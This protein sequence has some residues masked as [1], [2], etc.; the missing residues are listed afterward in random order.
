MP[1]ATGETIRVLQEI[2]PAARAHPRQGPLTDREMRWAKAA[3]TYFR[4]NVN[5]DT[6]LAG[7]QPNYAPFT[8]WD[9]SAHIAAVVAARNFGFIDEA[10]FDGR[11]RKI[12]T[13]L[14]HMELFRDTLPN[15][16]YSADNGKMVDWANQPGAL[17]WS[18]LD[19]GRFLVWLKILK[20][21]FP[22]YAELVDR[23]VMRWDWSKLMDREGLMYGA[24]YYQRNENLLIH[25][26][27]GRLG[28]EEYCARGFGLWGADTTKA[29][30]YEPFATV[31]VSGEDI[32]FDARD[33]E[34]VHAP[35]F[36]VSESYVLDGIEN[37]WDWPDDEN[38]D[39][40]K[41]SDRQMAAFAWRVYKAQENRYRETGIL[42]ART[43]DAVDQ[44]PY[45]VYGT[46]LGLGIPW[47]T[48]SH[49]GEPMP[50]LACLNSKAAL[51]LWVLFASDY[52]DLLAEAADSL[53]DPEKGFYVGRYEPTGKINSAVTLNGNGVILEIL[54]FKDTGK[55]LVHSGKPSHWDLFFQKH[56][57]PEKA[58]PPWKYQPRIT[59]H[60][61]D[62]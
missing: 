11:I 24:S 9:I 13:W 58:L 18:A 4:N 51:G 17:G 55:L 15:Q 43:E 52:T 39:V 28:Y 10:E 12:L 41:H 37:N 62:P 2:R 29:S 49:E 6:G 56:D 44:A 3:W 26:V 46:I 57:L 22:V 20:E 45:F 40:T 33:L 38:R 27:E 59:V 42:T 32:P 53:Y 16:F 14:N 25:Y 23:G 8:L 21:R 50:E 54:L 7:A 35:N 47:N 34:N 1:R 36:V 5:P 61:Y 30:E 48:I 19:L 31:R 60:K